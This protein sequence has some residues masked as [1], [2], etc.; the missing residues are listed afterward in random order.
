M[1]NHD[2]QKYYFIVTFLQ[3]PTLS[4][5]EILLSLIKKF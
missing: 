5:N 1:K 2:Y 3:Y 4:Y